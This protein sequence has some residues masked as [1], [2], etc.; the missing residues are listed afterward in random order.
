MP[1]IRFMSTVNNNIKR[2]CI[3]YPFLTL[4]VFLFLPYPGN[5][6]NITKYYKISKQSN[7]ILY[8]VMPKMVFENSLNGSILNYDITYLTVNDSATVN[9]SYLNNSAILIDSIAIIQSSKKFFSKT[10]KIFI[11]P[12]KST[13]NHRYSSRFLFGDLTF[14]FNQET[15]PKILIYSNSGVSEL[16]IKQKN[17]IKNADIVSK[18][19]TMIRLSKEK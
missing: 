10:K 4:L 6:Q 5:G 2:V 1:H 19:F 14:V 7:G 17:W 8:F 11:E 18:V 3:A 16:L 12:Q 13:W 9:F 15:D